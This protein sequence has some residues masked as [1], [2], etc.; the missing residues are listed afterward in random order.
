MKEYG[1]TIAQETRLWNANKLE[2]YSMRSKEEAHDYRYFPDP[3]LTPIVIDD[4]MIEKI[5]A[6]L[7]ELPDAKSARFEKEYGIP[8]YDA[9]VLSATR[10]LGDYYEQTVKLGANPK[11][12]SNWI[13]SE[14]LANVSDTEKMSEFR[15][16]PD[17]LSKLIRLMDSDVI[18]G[19]I[20]KMIF[21]EMLE[22]GGDPEAIVEAKG[23]KQ[24]TDS[25]A[26]ESVVDKVLAA[27]PQSIADFKA[28]KGKA[29]GF[30]VGQ[31]MKE[32]GGKANPQ[33]VNEILQKKLSEV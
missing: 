23:L 2:T 6:E 33:M 7:P 13:M 28:G 29:M 19:K 30:L 8:R 20:A 31:V 18:S 3:D 17:T 26:I 16:Q 14:L 22:N 9:D 32:S 4:A 1:E 24:V 5:R 10:E 11:K 27:N 15:I 25:G 12:A 21:A